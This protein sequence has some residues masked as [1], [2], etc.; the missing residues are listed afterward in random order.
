MNGSFSLKQLMRFVYSVATK[1]EYNKEGEENAEHGEHD[2]QESE[3]KSLTNGSR[4]DV[5]KS[6]KDSLTT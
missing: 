2:N 5:D 1:F 4:S 6:Q 3:D